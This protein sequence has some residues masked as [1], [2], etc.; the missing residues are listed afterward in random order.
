MQTLTITQPFQFEGNRYTITVSDTPGKR[1]KASLWLKSVADDLMDRFTGARYDRAVIAYERKV[2]AAGLKAIG[3][4]LPR[5]TRY[6]RNLGCSCGCSP[7][8]SLPDYGRRFSI[9][10]T[11]AKKSRGPKQTTEASQNA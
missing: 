1:G 7:G 2:L 3:G 8:F 11:R 4:W 5:G 9:E 6:R 10:L